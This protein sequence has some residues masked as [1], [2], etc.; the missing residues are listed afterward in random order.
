MNLSKLLISLIFISISHINIIWT[1]VWKQDQF[2]YLN[3]GDHV[4]YKNWI[5]NVSVVS[6][7]KFETV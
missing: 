7:I 3:H 4:K 2:R 1:I 5:S 6:K